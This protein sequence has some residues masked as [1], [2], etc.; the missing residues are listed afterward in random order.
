VRPAFSCPLLGKEQLSGTALA[1]RTLRASRPSMWRLFCTR[2]PSRARTAAPST[3]PMSARVRGKNARKPSPVCGF[4]PLA[5][6][7][8]PL[9]PFLPSL[10]APPH[11]SL[12]SLPMRAPSLLQHG[13]PVP[14]RPR[15]CATLCR[16]TC[17][18]T[19]PW[20]P[21]SAYSPSSTTRSERRG[22]RG[23]G[24]HGRVD[25]G[26]GRKGQ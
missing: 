18:S 21:R 4:P 24:S 8:V 26:A 5:S 12:L 15:G 13:R 7:S 25:C 17:A 9:H 14:K 2:L 20:P 6:D 11:P 1:A 22:G 19:Q 23:A 3:A 16:A 10:T